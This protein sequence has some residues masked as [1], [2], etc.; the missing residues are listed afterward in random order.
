V[1]WPYDM[2]GLAFIAT[3]PQATFRL[4]TEDG[5]D[6]GRDWLGLCTA[7][8]PGKKSDSLCGVSSSA[9]KPLEFVPEL[10]VV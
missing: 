9:D 4:L 8:S 10:C 3:V 2:R 5:L 7:K 1:F 6:G